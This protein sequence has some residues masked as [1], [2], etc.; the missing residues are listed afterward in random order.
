MINKIDASMVLLTFKGKV[1]LMLRDNNPAIRE[2][3]TWCFIGGAREE[4]ESFE[5]AI[6]REV[7]EETNIKLNQ[8]RFLTSIEYNDRQKCFYH[9]ELQEKDIS[10]L[11]VGEGQKQEFFKVDDLENLQLATSTRM[12]IEKH[13]DILN[14]VVSS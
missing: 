1:L 11:K 7:L 2:P 9:A 6:L 5:Q 10:N 8:V 4:H 3:N 14:H 13:R 12:F